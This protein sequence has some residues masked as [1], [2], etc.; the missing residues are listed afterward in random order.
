LGWIHPGTAAVPDDE[1]L[2]FKIDWSVL[3][4]T[5]WFCKFYDI[6]LLT[7]FVLIFWQFMIGRE[8]SVFG[9]T[10]N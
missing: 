8:A 6:W 2:A 10:V 7:V 5:V 4:T 1:S 9:S 3:Q